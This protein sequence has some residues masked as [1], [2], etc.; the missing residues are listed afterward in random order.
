MPGFACNSAFVL[1]LAVRRIAAAIVSFKSP[2]YKSRLPALFRSLGKLGTKSPCALP[3]VANGSNFE[4]SDTQAIGPHEGW[5]NKEDCLPS[6]P[7]HFC[8]GSFTSCLAIARPSAATPSESDSSLLTHP[9]LPQC[10]F[11]SFLFPSLP[12]PSSH[13]PLTPIVSRHPI[14]PLPTP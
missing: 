11:P 7:S 3:L 1:S 12:T 5:R 8:F 13:P 6:V 10:L 9:D 4:K 14:S 2:E